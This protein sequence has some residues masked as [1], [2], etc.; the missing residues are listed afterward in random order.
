MGRESQART[1]APNLT[2]LALK[3]WAAP[4]IPKIGIFGAKNLPQRGISPEPI[5]TK[6]GVGKGLRGTHHHAKFYCSGFVNVDLQPKISPK[7][8]FL[9]KFAPKGVYPLRQFFLQNFA[10]EREPQDRTLMRN[11]TVVALKMW[12]YTPK[13]A[14]NGIFCKNLPLKKNSG[15]R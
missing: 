14:K 13:V 10:W 6:F 5:F 4:K 7:M 2:L 11:F 1:L 3:M 8:L 12:P 9:Y 15:G